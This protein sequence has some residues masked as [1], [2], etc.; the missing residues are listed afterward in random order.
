MSGFAVIFDRTKTLVNPSVLGSIMKRLNHRGP[1]GQDTWHDGAVAMGHLHFWTTP[2]EN[3]ERQPLKL[4]G[5]P[6][7]IVLDGRL[8]NRPDLINRLNIHSEEAHQLSDAG[9]VLIAYAR[10]GT[11]CFKGMIGEYALVIND[12]QKERIVCAR[13]PVGDRTLFYSFQGTHVVI[14]SEPWAV[15]AGLIGQLEI[16]DRAVAYHFSHRMPEDGQTFFK[17]IYELLPAHW[18]AVNTDLVEKQRYWHPNP[19]KRSQKHPEAE[20]IEEFRELLEMSVRCRLR[21][22]TPPG[23]MMSGGLDSTSIA[24]LA[25]RMLAPAQLTTISYVFDKFTDCDERKYINAIRDQYGTRTIEVLSDDAW[26]YRTWPDWPIDPSWPPANPYRLILESTYSRARD[27]GF[28]VL[29]TGMYG[30]NLYAGS[31]EWLTDLMLDGR[32]HQ[33]SQEIASMSTESGLSS[34]IRSKVFMRLIKQLLIRIP[35]MNTLRKNPVPPAWLTPYAASFIDLKSIKKVSQQQDAMLTLNNAASHTREIYNT[36]RY[37]LELRNP[38][39]DQRL[40][41]FVL[42]LPGYLLY[43]HGISRFILR[44]AMTGILPEVI[45]SRVGKTD[46][47]TFYDYGVEQKSVEIERSLFSDEV[48]WDKYVNRDFLY[49]NW[50]FENSTLYKAQRSTIPALCAFFDL[51]Q[52][53][54]IN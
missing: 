51:W 4:R 23:I 8:D 32:Y 12:P 11:D 44:T 17:D 47:L 46:L 30:D 6:Y 19:K 50:Q 42:G 24:C 22:I 41:E 45:R 28:R 37:S 18:M 21:A 54:L 33:F 29:L 13:D 27:E 35:G 31:S 9:L 2:E 3:G 7:T 16:D 43:S 20:Y 1:D 15:T 26:P 5:L 53:S 39:R 52:K 25:A 49:N 40:I 48:F 14:A 36:N 34:A 38:F 10:W